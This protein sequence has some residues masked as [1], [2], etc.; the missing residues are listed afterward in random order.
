MTGANDD[1]RPSQT[2]LDS[3][4][5]LAVLR[6]LV[7]LQKL[8]SV[9]AVARELGLSQ[10]TVSANLS[11]FEAAIGYPILLRTTTGTRLTGEGATIVSAARPVLAAADELARAIAGLSESA[12][13]P[14]RIAA[15]LTVAEQLVPRWLADS[16]MAGHL[17]PGNATLVVGNSDEVMEWIKHDQADIGFIEGNT[18]RDGLVQ[19]PIANDVLVAVVGPGHR[20]F[21][22]TGPISPQDL[23]KAGLVIRE[24][25]SGTREVLENA[26]ARVG[27]ALPAHPASFGST[28]A[29]LTAVRHGGAVAVVSR[30]AVDDELGGGRLRAL[31]V[32]DLD[33][34]RRL[35]AVWL[36][37]RPPHGD[38]AT[39]TQNIAKWAPV[40]MGAAGDGII[41]GAEPYSR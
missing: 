26:L 30:L 15:S 4:I 12:S 36:D 29:I 20:W 13:A 38:A 39:L 7:E 24:P 9:G 5:T 17:T 11:R 10:P 2:P 1:D 6:Q 40:T 37:S 28:S 31:T 16:R 34:T 23:V 3:R 21:S 41:R 25:G 8:G 19:L 33:L 14:V 32:P 18:I 35:S 22:E 27:L